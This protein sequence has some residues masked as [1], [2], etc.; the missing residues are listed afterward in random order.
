MLAKQTA[1]EVPIAVPLI[2]RYITVEEVVVV[3]HKVKMRNKEISFKRKV[4]AKKDSDC[5]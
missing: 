4:F 3:Q 2:W 1:T 5:L